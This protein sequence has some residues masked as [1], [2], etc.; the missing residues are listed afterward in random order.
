MNDISLKAKIRNMAEEYHISAQAVLQS[1]LMRRFLFRLSHSEYADKFV[2]K[3]GMLISS[4]IGIDHRTTMDLDVTLQN[5]PLTEKQIQTAFDSICRIPDDDGITYVFQSIAPIRSDD[6]YGGFRVSFMAEYGKIHDP[7]TMDVSTGDV[8]TPGARRYSFSDM[9]NPED[10]CELWAYSLET[11]LAEKIETILSR[12]VDNTRPRDFYDVYLLSSYSYDPVIFQ[13]AFL[14][15]AKH[16]G[17]F[18]NI[19]DHG[20]ILQDILESQTMQKH[21]LGYAKQMPYAAGIDFV[22]TIQAVRKILG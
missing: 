19:N 22:E 17:S 10:S 6:K 14:E 7:M 15:T 13:E 9:F 16:R 21:W 20:K 1:Y 11:V 18:G 5:L 2:V 12:G 8:M 4:I 3:G